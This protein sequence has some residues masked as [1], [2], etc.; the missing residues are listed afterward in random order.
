MEEFLQMKVKGL[1]NLDGPRTPHS[2]LNI[3]FLMDMF[4]SFFVPGNFLS[5]SVPLSKIRLHHS[6]LPFYCNYQQ[7]Q[8]WKRILGRKS[9]CIRIRGKFQSLTNISPIAFVTKKSTAKKHCQFF[10]KT[11]SSII[12][13]VRNVPQLITVARYWDSIF[14]KTEII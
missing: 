1:S 10:Q 8:F 7:E 9:H 3:V 12:D 4:Y 2:F 14:N 13:W 5:E 11:P 6:Y